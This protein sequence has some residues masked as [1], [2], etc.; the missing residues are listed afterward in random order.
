MYKVQALVINKCII[1]FFRTSSPMTE[2]NIISP[3]VMQEHQDTLEQDIPLA[4][5]FVILSLSLDLIETLSSGQ[6]A[7][8]SPMD[9]TTIK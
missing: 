3:E 8:I 5:N 6:N 2:R 9:L 4:G 1:V 7:T